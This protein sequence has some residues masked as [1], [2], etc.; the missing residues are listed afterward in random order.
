MDHFR[1]AADY[2]MGDNQPEQARAC[3]LKVAQLAA[4]AEKFDLAT[5]TFEKVA[6][7]EADYNLLRLNVPDTLLR[8]GLCQLAGAG[9][10]RKGSVNSVLRCQ[11]LKPHS[12]SR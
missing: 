3:L 7:H 1:Q 8:A 5:E 10:I 11:V 2:Y 9:P 6:R 4:L 12:H